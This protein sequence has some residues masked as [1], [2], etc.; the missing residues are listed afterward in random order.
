MPQGL[1]YW[2]GLD[3]LANEGRF[4]WAESHEVAEYTNWWPGQPDN[5][6]GIEDCTYKTVETWANGWNDDQCIVTIY[7][8][9]GGI[10]AICEYNL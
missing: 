6:A 8:P 9:I 10:H 4:I 3:D 7:E 1:V 2:I 5:S